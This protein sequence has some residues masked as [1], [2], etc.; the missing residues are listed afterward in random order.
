VPVATYVPIWVVTTIVLIAIG[1]GISVV[2]LRSVVR[3]LDI[4]FR[5]TPAPAAP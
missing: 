5:F 4:G 2:W 1:I 3:R